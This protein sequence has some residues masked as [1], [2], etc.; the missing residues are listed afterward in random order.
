[1]SCR[2]DVH[3]R[4]LQSGKTLKRIFQPWQT[5]SDSGHQLGQVLHFMT[6]ESRRP[7]IGRYVNEPIF[8]FC[9]GPRGIRG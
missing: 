2:H 9:R 1:M 3:D 7:I 5:A 6:V 8:F 4:L